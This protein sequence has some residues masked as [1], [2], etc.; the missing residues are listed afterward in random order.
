MNEISKDLVIS[1]NTPGGLREIVNPKINFEFGNAQY[2]KDMLDL[3]SKSPLTSESKFPLVVLFYPIDENR[4]SGEYFTQAKVNLLI[5]CSS[6]KD[7][8][9]QEREIYSFK[10]ILRPIYERSMNV[11]RNNSDLDFGYDEKI[12]HVYSENYSYGR[13][14]AYSYSGE[15]VSEPIEIGRAHV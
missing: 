6:R 4:N 7:W 15:S 8:S 11:L 10:N 9:N 5:A 1:L 2:I 13:Y 3:Y 14:G 12:Q